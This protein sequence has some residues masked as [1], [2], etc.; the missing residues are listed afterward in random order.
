MNIGSFSIKAMNSVFHL[1][2]I[3]E[4]QAFVAYTNQ[5]VALLRVW[6][7][8]DF[9]NYSLEKVCCFL[10]IRQKKCKKYLDIR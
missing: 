3:D 2:P 4:R 10:I 8:G 6:Q 7:Q 5:Q 1:L 9:F